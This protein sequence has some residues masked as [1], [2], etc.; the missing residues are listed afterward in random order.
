MSNRKIAGCLFLAILALT[1]LFPG[2]DVFPPANSG[3]S[4]NA[5][6]PGP[7]PDPSRILAASND[8]LYTLRLEPEGNAQRLYVNET[9]IGDA[10]GALYWERLYFFTVNGNYT[11]REQKITAYADEDHLGTC[12]Y[13]SYASEKYG[14]IPNAFRVQVIAPLYEYFSSIYQNGTSHEYTFIDVSG[15][16]TPRELDNDDPAS[17]L[18]INAATGEIVDFD[19]IL[20]F[21]Y[22]RPTESHAFTVIE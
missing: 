10:T 7:T 1:V 21:Y 13:G 5:P 19:S 14:T 9:P 2:C 11:R 8:D 4:S 15:R 22:Q 3:N 18:I 12:S 17:Y 20:N 6:I 16:L